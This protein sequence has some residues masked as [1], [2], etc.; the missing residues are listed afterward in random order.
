M[1]NLQL[2]KSSPLFHLINEMDRSIWNHNSENSTARSFEPSVDVQQ[3][4]NGYLLTFDLPGVNPDDIKVDLKKNTLIVTATRENKSEEKTQRY[5]R[6]ERAFGKFE[7]SFTLPENV[8]LNKIDAHYDNGVLELIIP[9]TLEE[10]P[11]TV[12]VQSG[13]KSGFLNKVVGDT[14]ANH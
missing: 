10:P 7:R 13:G 1:T 9:K 2:F 12:K 8:D 14:K 6:Q 11:K 5:F 3:N 4:E